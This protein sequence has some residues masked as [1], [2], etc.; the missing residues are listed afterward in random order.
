MK[1]FLMFRDRD[2]DS[3]QLLSRRDRELR[4]SNADKQGLDL[5]QLLPW[6]GAAL[7]QDLGLDFVFKAMSAD[8]KFLLEVAQVALLSS[9]TDLETIL[10]RQCVL[11]DCLRNARVV[12]EIYQLSVE[13]IENERKNY[14]SLFGRFPSVTLHRAV[15][16]LSMFV[17]VLKKLRSAAD[18]HSEEFASEGFSRLFAMLKQE[19]GDEYFRSVERHLQRLKFRQGILISA[20]LGPGNKAQNY[21]L[22]RPHQDRR[23]WL[24]RL[25]AEKPPAYS[26]ELHPRDEGGHRAL[27][28]LGDRG[29]NLVANALAQSTDHILSFF[30]MLR[31]ELAFY[32]GCLNL[33]AQLQQLRERNCLPVPAPTGER[34]LTF[35][36]L[37][38]VALAL[39]RREKVVGND[40]DAD[41][42]DIL[43]ITGANTGGK[44][45][46]LRSVGLAQLMM[47]SGMFVPAESFS[48]EVCDGIFTHYKREE[49]VAM[50]SGKWDEELSR[51]SE[52]VNHLKPN[53]IV[54]FNESFASTNEREGS[55]IAAQIVEA[56]LQQHVKVSFVTH[57][58]HFARSICDQQAGNAIFLRAERRPDGTRPFKLIEAEPLQ[59]S[60]GEDLYTTIFNPGDQTLAKSEKAVSEA[61]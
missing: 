40:A 59:T 12:R 37:Y 48:A 60:Y 24:T 21:V 58:Y 9:V 2:F 32:V 54:L 31:A 4:Y 10:Y 13:A 5:E 25:L 26:F 39:S 49:D 16:L 27:A 41:G 6:N 55:E 34:K 20:Q 23:N 30:Q 38:D 51:M 44:S 36:G 47:Q 50:E 11:S 1:A 53:S 52:I 3:K 45:T 7:R 8:D 56:L 33:H 28:E 15:E 22:R 17:V 18:Q 57:L 19:L 61:S 42:K 29:I 46:F 43:I 14:W 35:S